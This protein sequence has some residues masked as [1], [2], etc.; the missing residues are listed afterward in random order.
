MSPGTH[1]WR[2]R[3][4]DLAGEVFPAHPDV[5]SQPSAQK[6]A[7]REGCFEPG[8]HPGIVLHALAC[9]KP[10]EVFVD[11]HVAGRGEPQRGNVLGAANHRRMNNCWARRKLVLTPQPLLSQ[12]V[13]MYLNTSLV[14]KMFPCMSP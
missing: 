13:R 2:E 7:N 6:T 12:L 10:V 4:R 1:P 5:H 8:F 9:Q 11:C 14:Q 3:V